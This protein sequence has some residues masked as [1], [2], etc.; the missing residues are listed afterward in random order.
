MRRA[1]TAVAS[2]QDLVGK[3][4]EALGFRCEEVKE[5]VDGSSFWWIFFHIFLESVSKHL[6]QCLVL[7]LSTQLY[8][9]DTLGRSL[10]ESRI[11][12]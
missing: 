7:F 6:H 9:S 4:H 1:N 5:D 8:C 11:L 2:E 3:P 10:F 12:V